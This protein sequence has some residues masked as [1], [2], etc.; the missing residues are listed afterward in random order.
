MVILGMIVLG[1]IVL[2]LETARA[3]VEERRFSAA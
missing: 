1:M 2:Q 3:T